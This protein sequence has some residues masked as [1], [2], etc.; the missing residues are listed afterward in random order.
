M[1]GYKHLE[2]GA[3]V[4]FTIC[5][6]GTFRPTQCGI[7]SYA[8]D[9]I[10]AMPRAQHR[11]VACEYG[12][13]PQPDDPL[14]LWRMPL[15][16]SKAHLEAAKRINAS[17]ADVV[18]LQ[19]EFGIYGGPD[20]EYLLRFL[21][22]LQKPMVTTL[23]TVNEEF[24]DKR[25]EIVRQLFRSSR[26]VVTLTERSAAI[27]RRMVPR[28]ANRVRVIE[29]GVHP[30]PFIEPAASPL[31]EAMEADWVFVS[32]GHLAPHKGY[33]DALRA[34]KKLAADGVDFRFL[35]LGRGQAQF[36]GGGEI[37]A[38]ITRL[39]D[40]L[41]LG[42]RVLRVADFMPTERMLQTFCAAD[43][44]L[45]TYNR[46]NHNSSG[47]LSAMLACGRPVVATDFE[48]AR[49]MAARTDAVLLARVGDA[50][51]IYRRIAELVQRPAAMA[52]RMRRAYTFMQPQHWP[53]VGE[54][55]LKLLREAARPLVAADVLA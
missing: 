37:E 22:R 42:G 13:P 46:A 5:H 40:E 19:H 51:D 47:V 30:V 4:A 52:M 11:V 2:P 15:A 14:V 34:L 50:D 36:G 21:R 18:S 8:E 31:R 12:Q 41:R 45:V 29:H 6:V 26:A 44:G 17:D 49:T 16:D 7:A 3:S 43:A 27:C 1:L 28:M 10:A 55:Y 33:D 9:L 23:H 20:G 25:I 32:S 38:S 54:A 24:N 39:V 53:K 35:I 48:F